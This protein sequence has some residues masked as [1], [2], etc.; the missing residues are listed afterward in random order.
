[1]VIFLHAL[2][3][4]SMQ[5]YSHKLGNAGV[6]TIN[7][8]TYVLQL[9]PIK[10]DFNV[11]IQRFASWFDKARVSNNEEAL[12]LLTNAID[13]ITPDIISSSHSKYN[14]TKFLLVN[15]IP[16]KLILLFK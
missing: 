5:W 16:M 4:Q 8:P 10:S 1:M 11:I 13:L 14:W 2:M 6:D 15:V 7:L 9:N 3:L 12:V